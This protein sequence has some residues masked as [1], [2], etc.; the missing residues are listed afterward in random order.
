M[1]KITAFTRQTLLAIG[2]DEALLAELNR[3]FKKRGILVSFGGGTFGGSTATMKLNMATVGKN[4]EGTSPE[5][6]AWNEQA[7]DFGLKKAWLGRTI[8]L[9]RGSVT[10]AGILTSRPRMPVLGLL[11]DGRR[12]AMA[13]SIV[14]DQLQK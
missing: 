12:V 5:E 8:Q 14:I 7:V 10:I 13:A 6:V 9:K 4:A 3:A 2:S 11:P 1:A